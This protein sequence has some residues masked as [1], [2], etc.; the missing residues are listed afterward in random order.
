[1]RAFARKSDP[2]TSHLAAESV[3]KI[4]ETQRAILQLLRKGPMTDEA[5][6]RLYRAQRNFPLAS[7]SGIRSRRADLVKLGLVEDSGLTNKTQFGR[8]AVL[9]KVV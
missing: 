8:L 7:D 1:M 5:L 3:H 2:I 9:W 4:S 6:I